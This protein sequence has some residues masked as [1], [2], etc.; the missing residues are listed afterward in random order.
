MQKTNAC[1]SLTLSKISRYTQSETL[2]SFEISDVELNR[3]RNVI[4]APGFVGRFERILDGN[5]TLD[6]DVC[7]FLDLSTCESVSGPMRTVSDYVIVCDS[8]ARL[9]ISDY[10]S[11]SR[12]QPPI[13]NRTG[14]RVNHGALLGDSR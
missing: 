4:W 10:F 11:L 3:V 6:P 14:K 8:Q 13:M 9:H 2:S 7:G 1:P 12:T 5:P